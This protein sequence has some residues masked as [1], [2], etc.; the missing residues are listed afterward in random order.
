MLTQNAM[1]ATPP[2]RTIRLRSRLAR[3]TARNM[4]NSD[5]VRQR[6]HR[7][8]VRERTAGARAEALRVIEGLEAATLPAAAQRRLLG[9]LRALV[10]QLAP[11]AAHGERTP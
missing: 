6:R 8:K 9:R 3:V 10:D 1:F 5:A 2:R 7:E 4:R 11:A